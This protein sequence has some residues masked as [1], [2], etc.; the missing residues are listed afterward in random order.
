MTRSGYVRFHQGA[1]LRTCLSPRG[2]WEPIAAGTCTL[3]A[4]S[5]P[6]ADLADSARALGAAAAAVTMAAP[7]AAAE[8]TAVHLPRVCACRIPRSFRSTACAGLVWRRSTGHRL[9]A[10]VSRVESRGSWPVVL[11][12]LG[13]SCRDQRFRCIGSAPDEQPRQGWGDLCRL[14]ASETRLLTGSSD[15][16]R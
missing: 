10:V 2:G 11:L 15:G 16:T 12:R 7:S 1:L 14:D 13:P 9:W 5:L 8:A 4:A 6:S 3:C